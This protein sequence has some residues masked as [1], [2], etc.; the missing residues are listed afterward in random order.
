MF[1]SVLMSTVW[2]AL[3][4]GWLH[5]FDGEEPFQDPTGGHLLRVAGHQIRPSLTQVDVA[6]GTVK[7]GQDLCMFKMSNYM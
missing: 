5:L 2:S 1:S 6:E 4:G 7:A 3:L